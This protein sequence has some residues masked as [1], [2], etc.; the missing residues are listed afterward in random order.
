M[1]R[2][3]ITRTMADAIVENVSPPFHVVCKTIVIVVLY[4]THVHK[5]KK[6]LQQPKKRT[7]DVHISLP[8][9]N[10]DE[11]LAANED[12]RVAKP[13]IVYVITAGWTVENPIDDF[14]EEVKY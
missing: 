6:R 12:G 5:S 14:L 4:L 11:L 7:A 8:S 10:W 13:E 3:H 9:V 2:V 1:Q